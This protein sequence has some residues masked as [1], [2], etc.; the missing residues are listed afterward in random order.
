MNIFQIV[1]QG[2]YQDL[3][4]GVSEFEKLI[5]MGEKVEEEKQ[6]NKVAYENKENVVSV[7]F[8]SIYRTLD[9]RV[10]SLRFI[11]YIPSYFIDIENRL[12]MIILKIYRLWEEN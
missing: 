7:H 3:Q 4:N 2:T 9:F 5:E 11:S 10:A 1:A 8:S 6:K 12:S